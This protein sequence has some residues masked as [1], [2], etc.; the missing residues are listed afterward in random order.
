MK[1]Q[2]PLQR[3]TARFTNIDGE[4]LQKVSNLGPSELLFLAGYCAGLAEHSPAQL[5]AVVTPSAANELS[6][7]S[8]LKALILYASQTGNAQEIAESLQQS[9][10]SKGCKTNLESTLDIKLARLKDYALIVV[11]ASTHGEGEPPDDA[12]DFYEAV[13]SKK[14]P[15]L[16]GVKHAVLGLGDSSYEFFCQ[17]AKDFDSAL[18]K[19]GSVPLIERLDCDVDYQQEALNW[20]T[21]LVGAIAD[22]QPP[23]LTSPATVENIIQFPY[24]KEKPFAATLLIIQKLTAR[25][26]IK[27]TYHLEIDLAGSGLSYGPGDALGVWADND[28]A[29]VKEILAELNIE[30]QA[31]VRFKDEEF[32]VEE[33]LRKKLEITLLN[34]GLIEAL[35]TVGG[36]QKLLEITETY[37]SD[38]IRNHQL[39]DV[40]KLANVTLEAQQLVAMLKPLK[41]RLYSISS[42]IDENPEEVHITLNHLQDENENGIR[43]GQAS[44]FLTR[45]LEEGDKVNV[46][47]ERNKNFKLP[48]S[49]KAIIMVGPGT[50]I[51]PFR[52]FLQQREAEQAKGRNWLFFGNPNFNTDFLYQTELQKHLKS[53]LLTQIDVAFSRDQ[54]QKIYVQDRL[55]ENAAQVWQWLEQGAFFYVC[56]DMSR[57]AKEVELALLQI[58]EQQGNNTQA[59]A[60]DY[61]KQLKK[62]ARYQRDVY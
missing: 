35:A 61:L 38:Y 29:L 12:I 15:S 20:T 34:K 16:N 49:D 36:S 26:S 33:L 25:G 23:T 39:I 58:I 59:Q 57:M 4:L 48:S 56:G 31:R 55:R 21:Q 28:K 2:N 17:T 10:E 32:S 45:Q 5:N 7:G 24:S 14:A 53:G 9:L 3:A 6:K 1:E 11:I 27:D 18:L 43:Y 51:A 13:L 30:S 42:S 41:P 22:I 37:Y 19:L 8:Q 62:Q 54:E 52:S 50:G 44:H 46:Y 60:K 47:V 40:L